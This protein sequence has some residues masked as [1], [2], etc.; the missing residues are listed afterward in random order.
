MTDL[1]T[2][3]LGLPLNGPLVPSAS[4]LSRSLDSALRLQE[5]GAGALV[6]YSLFEEE[7]R[8]DETLATRH[9]LDQQLGHAE[10]DSFLPLHDRYRHAEE[11]YLEQLQRLKKALD[12][13]VIA[14]LNGITPGGWLEHARGL[15]QAGADALEMNIHFVATD[16]GQSA[17]EIESRY[18]QLLGELLRQVTI[19]VAVKLGPQFSSLPAMVA[20]LEQAGANGVVLFNRFYQPDID[21]DTLRLNQ[22]LGYSTSRDVLPVL[23]W[24]GILHGR[25]GVSLAASGGVHTAEDALKLFAAGSDVVQLCSVLLT[26]GPERLGEIRH[27]VAAWLEQRGYASLEEFRGCVSRMHADQPVLYERANDFRI[28]A[29]WHSVRQD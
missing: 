18:I 27:A 20:R 21:L 12:I 23:R 26:S 3:Y 17:E 4:P 15:Q 5:A 24:I 29:Q 28:L 8:Q 19:P 11:H 9:L 10:A 2:D 6:M 1:S 25:T 22:Y 13:P 7:I 14:S 16:P